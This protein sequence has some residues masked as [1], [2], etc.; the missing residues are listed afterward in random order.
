MPIKNSERT[1]DYY[2]DYSILKNEDTDILKTAVAGMSKVVGSA[3]KKYKDTVFRMLMQDKSRALEVYN[4]MNNT[5]YDDPD[6]LIVTTLES[7][8][9]MGV[10]NDHSFIIDMNLVLYE[11]QSTINENMPLRNLE[12]V[13]CLFSA[14]TSNANLYGSRLIR[15]PEPQFVVFYNGKEKLPERYEL[16]LSDAYEKHTGE[17]ALELKVDVV[18]I[19]Q[20]YNKD[21]ME[22]SP[23]L[24]QYMQFVDAVRSFDESYP[25]EKAM[26]LAIESCIKNDILAEFLSRNRAEVLRTSIFEYD[27]EKHI[28]QEKEESW[29]E[30]RAQGVAEGRTEGIRIG[31]EL[32]I[33]KILKAQIERKMKKGLSLERIAEDLEYSLEEIKPIYDMVKEETSEGYNAVP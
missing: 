7:A 10:R 32:G 6:E 26:D 28:K 19:N 2:L 1:S 8:V 9:Y 22:K 25:F 15:L 24:Y 3:N 11:H 18:N 27:Q 16:K 30:G 20:G 31:E 17:P 5:N 4:A 12:Y 23:T 29:E 13:T 14:L 21:L 33:Q